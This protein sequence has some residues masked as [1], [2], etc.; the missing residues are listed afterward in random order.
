MMKLVALT[1]ATVSRV[2]LA[3]SS[4]GQRYIQAFGAALM[5]TQVMS[6]MTCGGIS[7]LMKIGTNARSQGHGD[8]QQ[9]LDLYYA[10]G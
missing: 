5:C 3:D 6:G 8:Q 2:M 7:Y 1:W 10:S 9:D 4:G